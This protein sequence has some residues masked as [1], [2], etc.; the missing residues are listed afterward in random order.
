MNL[1]HQLQAASTGSRR[2][3]P[4]GENPVALHSENSIIAA[5][6][7]PLTISDLSARTGITVSG[8]WKALQRLVQKGQVEVAARKRVAK[9]TV[10]YWRARKERK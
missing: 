5:L 2:S 8:V 3:I 6:D 9:T 4:S 1:L 10:R 7:E